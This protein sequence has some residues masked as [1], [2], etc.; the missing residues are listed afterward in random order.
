[1][2]SVLRDIGRRL[3]L[4]V[5][6]GG[7]GSFIGPVHRRAARFDDCFELVAGVL[8]R[9]PERSAALA[10]GLGISAD[11]AYGDWRTMLQTES[12]RADPIDV[13]AIMTPNDLHFGPANLAL[14]LG[15]DVICDKPLSVNKA[16]ADKLVAKADVSNRVFCVTYNYSQYPMVRQARALIGQGR[17]G[18]VRQVHTTYVQGHNAI[19]RDDEKDGSNWRFER[20]RAGASL[21][22][23]DIGSHAMHLGAYVS[24][25]QPTAVM[26]DIC[27]L[28]PGRTSDDYGSVLI[29]WGDNGAR[30]TLWVTNSAAGAEHGLS[31][32]VFGETGG[33]EWHQEEPNSL[34]HYRHGQFQERQTRRLHGGLEPLAEHATRIEIG[35]PEGYQEAFASLYK[36][37]AEVIAARHT[38]RAPN[39]LAIDFPT[40]LDGALGMAFI[41]AAVSSHREGRWVAL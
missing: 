31:F 11:R 6:G 16:E 7:Q 17:I 5:I 28:V 21:I 9:N 35:H 36:D 41:E 38:G 26:A 14:E 30:G 25:L 37:V 18:E 12:Q 2:N 10:Q 29:K 3:R 20:E 39:P 15:F 8:S 4:G 13:V 1:M 32:R 34:I 33:F 19:L 27:G 23:G 22:L 40:V 24:S